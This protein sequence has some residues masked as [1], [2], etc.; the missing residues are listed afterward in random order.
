MDRVR[1]LVFVAFA[2]CLMCVMGIA[3]ELPAE[4]YSCERVDSYAEAYE[5]SQRQGRPLL[6]FLTLDNCLPCKAVKKNVLDPMVLN[7]ECDAVMVEVAIDS[8]L[9][10]KIRSKDSRFAPQ[11]A[12]FLEVGGKPLKRLCVAGACT[13]K[14][15][16]EML[17]R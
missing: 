14:R 9:G 11:I 2:S 7:P 15:V 13:A 17:A 6:V 12:V 10:E 16:R 1:L 8:E 5:R 4:R 3:Q